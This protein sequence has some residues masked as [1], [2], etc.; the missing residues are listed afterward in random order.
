MSDTVLEPHAKEPLDTDV[1]DGELAKR[2]AAT[3]GTA[4][5]RPGRSLGGLPPPPSV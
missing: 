3:W 2:L 5:G 1:P 4:D